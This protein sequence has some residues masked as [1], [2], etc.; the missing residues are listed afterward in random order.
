MRNG[1]IRMALAFG[2]AGALCTGLC[3]TS[4]YDPAAYLQFFRD[5]SWNLTADDSRRAAAPKIQD[6]IGLTDAEVEAL[7]A[8]AEDCLSSLDA[9]KG[10]TAALTLESRLEFVQFGKHSDALTHKLK[11]LEEQQTDV[12]VNH[13]QQLKAALAD[14]SFGRVDAYVR[15][16]ADAKKTLWPSNPNP[17]GAAAMPSRKK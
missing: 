4:R 2:L 9:F 14:A 3:Q 12:V 10:R 17:S 8:A 11:Q 5:V 16:P 15:T 6:V 1:A 13:V 7:S